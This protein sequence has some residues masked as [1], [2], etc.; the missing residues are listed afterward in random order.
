MSGADVERGGSSDRPWTPIDELL[1][2][3]RDATPHY[4]MPEL[5]P[6]TARI[7]INGR[8]VDLVGLPWMRRALAS[9]SE[10][11]ESVGQRRAVYQSLTLELMVHSD[12]LLTSVGRDVV[13]DGRRLRDGVVVDEGGVL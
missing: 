13:V 11:G 2:V 7:T 12:E 4:T 5:V 9:W 10:A 6:V 3:T 8:L 1:R